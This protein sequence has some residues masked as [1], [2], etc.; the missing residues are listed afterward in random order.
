[1]REKER[2]GWMDGWMEGRAV[3]GWVIGMALEVEM[4]ARSTRR[5][6]SEGS[7]MV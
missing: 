6:R 2:N 3:H 4:G 7:W 1:M 5:R